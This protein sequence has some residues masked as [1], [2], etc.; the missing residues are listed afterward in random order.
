MQE[1]VSGA[2][3]IQGC[4]VKDTTAL[5][6]YSIIASGIDALG[7][8][9]E[10]TYKLATEMNPLWTSL[11]ATAPVAFFTLYMVINCAFI[12]MLAIDAANGHRW[13]TWGLAFVAIIKTLVVAWHVLGILTVFVPA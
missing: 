13:A 10:V 4:D 3:T 6:L 7:T 11:V 2:R 1:H 12:S 9:V 5:A 8:I